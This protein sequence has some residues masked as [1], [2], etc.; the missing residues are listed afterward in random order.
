MNGFAQAKKIVVKVGTSTLTHGTGLINIRRMERFVKTLADLKNSGRDLILVSSGAIGVGVGKLGLAA[1]PSDTP[2]KQAA[3]AVGQCE[4]MY[5]YDKLFSE[6]NHPVA[7]V[8]L[9]RDVVELSARKA[10]CVNTFRRLLEMGVIP[11]V[12]ENDT[13]AVEEIEFGDNDTLSAM[14][15]VLAGADA[16]VILTDIDGLYEEDPR[17]NPAAALIPEVEEVTDEILALAGGVGSSRG[18]GGMVTKLHAAQIACP[19]GIEMAIVNGSDPEILYDLFEG[20][21]VGTRFCG[22]RAKA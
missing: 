20:K 10:N 3:A 8:L 14:V 13:V 22:K 2:S 21:A 16:L 6:Y 12:N 9:T 19:A 17:K 15:A 11:V 7:Q 18:T 5:L 1:R 4:L